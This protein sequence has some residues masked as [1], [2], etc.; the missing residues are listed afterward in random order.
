MHL[1]ADDGLSIG[2]DP[3]E[4]DCAIFKKRKRESKNTKIYSLKNIVK[5]RTRKIQ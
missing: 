4:D 3:G 5:T 2:S 1:G